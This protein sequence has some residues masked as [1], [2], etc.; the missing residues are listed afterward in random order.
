MDMES[1]VCLDRNTGKQRWK[2]TIVSLDQ[3]TDKQR[4]NKIHAKS[5]ALMVGTLIVNDG[6]VLYAEPGMLKALSAADGKGMWTQRITPRSGLWFKWKDV[7][8]IDG[9]VWTWGP[10]A[11]IIGYDL[12][13][14][15][16]KREVP[17]G[18]VFHVDHHHRCYRNKATSR[19]LIAS[20]RGAEFMDLVNGKHT[21]HSWV[22]GICHYGMMPA[23][24]LLYAP[25]EPCRCFWYERITGFAALAAEE[26]AASSTSRERDAERLVKGR[27]YSAAGGQVQKA[28]KLDW[29]A[30]RADGSRSSST[31]ESLPANIGKSWEIQ[32]PGTLS[33]PI[34][35]SEHMYVTAVDAH[36]VYAL[37]ASSGRKVWEYTAGGR[38]DS[39]PAYYEG[40]L[41]FGCTDGWVT[42]LRASDGAVA[43]RFLAAPEERLMGAFSQLESA[44][45]V[46]GSVLIHDDAA[47]FAAGRSSYLDGGIHVFALDPKT[48]KVL[49]QTTVKGPE[50]DAV[51]TN[52]Y[53]GYKEPGGLGALNDILQASE[54]L[55][56]MRNR[57]F[58]KTLKQTQSPV[59]VQTMGGYLD[60]T[61]F[62]RYFAFYGPPMTIALNAS[63]PVKVGYSQILVNDDQYLYGTRMFDK[64]KLL[65]ADNYFVPA[66]DGYLLF[67]MEK[68]LSEPVWSNRVPVRVKSMVVT[69]DQLIISGAP[70]MVDPQDPLGAFE[71]RKGGRVWTISSKD[72]RKL[73][74]HKLDSPPVF[75]G[76][77]VARGRLFVSQ[78]NGKVVCLAE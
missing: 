16:V 22:R 36:T 32:L 9:L 75:N 21:V 14:G 39:P 71:A 1:I 28:G 45:P 25:P 13:T 49:H 11:K 46:H 58:D 62:K 10:A 73:Q 38:V 20:R 51:N 34:A 23:N 27:A 53:E 78:R 19:Y 64:L 8:V 68:G 29:P 37:E 74:E 15:D 18:K 59:R 3:N 43:W 41:L 2:K 52:W 35:V 33:A 24:G 76:M 42:C 12:K 65:N 72:G 69:P 30:F 60:D 7:F 6:V 66:R 57:A 44:W 40:R 77:A 61:Y 70:D 63:R 54:G 47:Y 31:K 55:I 4:W 5:S 67:K 48:G 26:N 56:C 17:T 50:V